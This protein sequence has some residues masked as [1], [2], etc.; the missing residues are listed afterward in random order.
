[1]RSSA[2]RGV[3][4]RAGP[5]GH[6]SSQVLGGQ[7]EAGGV[8]DRADQCRQRGLAEQ[9]EVEV[10]ATRADGLGYRLGLG[11]CEHEGDVC[12]RLL[13]CLQEGTGGVGGELVDLVDDV[14][15]APPRGGEGHVG[16]QLP[17][18]LQAELRGG[19]ELCHV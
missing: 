5:L 7:V 2:D 12:W 9:A 8:G 16:E 18:V 11:R 13:Q 4:G 17:H 19:V 3:A 14:D 15:L 1:M 10:L 6:G